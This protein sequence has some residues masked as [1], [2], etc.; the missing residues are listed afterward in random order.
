MVLETCFLHTDPRNHEKNSLGVRG[1][2]GFTHESGDFSP[3]VS[4]KRFSAHVAE[5]RRP[6]AREE[7]S[8][9]RRKASSRRKGMSL[10]RENKKTGRA[11][12]PTCFHQVTVGKLAVQ[13]FAAIGINFIL[14][15]T[16]VQD[17]FVS[18]LAFVLPF[19]LSQERIE[20]P[21]N[22]CSKYR[23]GLENE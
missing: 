13:P 10:W 2:A 23:P 12:R 9:K 4:G 21:R 5:E 7:G 16:E 17:L 15:D 18:D 22:V 20:S 8:R 14:Q 6:L 3:D 1:K 19:P 11:L